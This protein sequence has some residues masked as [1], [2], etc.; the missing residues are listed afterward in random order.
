METSLKQR[1]ED[2]YSA[3]LPVFLA[4]IG[5]IDV[6]GIPDPHLP[7]WGKD[8]ESASPR[9]A[10]VGQ[11]TLYWGQMDEF[12]D[13][14]KNDLNAAIFGHGD[15]F[16]DLPFTGWTNNFGTTFWDTVMQFLAMFRG[17][18]DWKQLKRRQRDDILQTFVW[19]Q[20]NA[21]ELWGS[22][23]S[24]EEANFES[25][26]TCKGAAERHLDS[27]AAFLNIFRP[28]LV[29][30]MNWTVRDE[31]WDLPLSFE[32]VGNY[33]DYAFEPT[34]GCHIFHT[35]HST[36]LRGGLRQEVF[37]T[38]RRKWDSVWIAPSHSPARELVAG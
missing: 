13:I 36:F 26:K 2:H 16:H 37:D 11:D 9:I 17:V 38:I 20:T 33:V 15:V 34:H 7:L 27:F 25:W 24:R 21:V 28:Q 8:Y 1:Y 3:R 4:E 18:P 14:A 23:P 10:F 29:V 6:T 35:A 32:R 5:D 12:R 31:Y 30:V 19:S 22:S